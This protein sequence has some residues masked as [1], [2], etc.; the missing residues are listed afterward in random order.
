MDALFSTVAL[1]TANRKGGV[2]DTGSLLL[3]CPGESEVMSR[4]V[5]RL[6]ILTAN[7]GGAESL[8]L[9]RAA[10]AFPYG[11]RATSDVSS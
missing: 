8:R 5:V 1:G 9:E 10:S 7:P 11:V 6:L 4:G 3:Y 2:D